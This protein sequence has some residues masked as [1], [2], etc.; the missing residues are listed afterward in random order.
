MIPTDSGLATTLEG[1]SAAEMAEFAQ[2]AH[3][4]FPAHGVA[5]A[6]VSTGV[7]IR[8]GGVIPFS[9][10]VGIGTHSLPAEEDLDLLEA[11]YDR[12]AGPL[13]VA[14][15]SSGPEGLERMLVRRGWK[16]TDSEDVLVRELDDKGERLE[17]LP[18]GVGEVAPHEREAWA[19][20]VV[21]GFCDGQ[22]SDKHRRFA[23][24][25]AARPDVIAYW[26]LANGSPVATGEL[27]L[28]GE[29]AWFSADATMPQ[30]R[31]QGLQERLQRA[32]LERAMREGCRYAVAE[33]RPDSVSH[34]NYQRLGFSVAYTRL[35]MSRDISS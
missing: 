12:Y 11:F 16:A 1:H 10:A 6:A 4:L 26:V 22:P 9:E 24:V 34:R 30:H 19:Q 28:R 20:C 3:E 27:L 5:L 33:A 32:R 31:G 8:G 25:L 18:D 17:S 35:W 23:R 29:Y 2:L 7:A 15:T 21:A 14:V 13:S